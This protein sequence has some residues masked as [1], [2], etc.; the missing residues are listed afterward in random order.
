[1]IKR[2]PHKT[3]DPCYGRVG[4]KIEIIQPLHRGG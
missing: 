2:V 3:I 1:M 4:L